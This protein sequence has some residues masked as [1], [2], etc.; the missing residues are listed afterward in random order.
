MRP[1]LLRAIPL[2][3]LLLFASCN[4][5]QNEELDGI[6]P[7]TAQEEISSFFSEHLQEYSSSY[8]GSEFNFS[9]KTECVVVNS[10][11]EF[12][13]MVHS[14]IPLPLIDF[15]KYS[16]ILWQTQMADPG[17]KYDCQSISVDEDS[18]LLILRLTYKRL[19]GFFPCA[20]Q[21]FHH[22]GLYEKLPDIPISLMVNIVD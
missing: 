10:Q 21:Y 2:M 6:P 13:S 17:F 3:L 11:D 22:W 16:L 15:S 19:H 1:H 4:G 9:Q 12:R 5:I 14:S 20:I 7:V 8:S 18:N